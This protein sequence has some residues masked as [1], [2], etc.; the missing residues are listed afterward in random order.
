VISAIR[1]AV[2][3]ASAF[4]RSVWPWKSSRSTTAGCSATDAEDAHAPNAMAIPANHFT[5]RCIGSL[6][7]E[8]SLDRTHVDGVA[9]ANLGLVPRSEEFGEQ[10]ENG[11][12][13]V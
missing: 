4:Q 7:C 12:E 6:L 2:S 8:E 13:S 11:L 5:L 1:Q 9:E 10:P 3:A